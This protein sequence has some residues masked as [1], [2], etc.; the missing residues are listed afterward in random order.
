MSDEHELMIGKG[1]GGGARGGARGGGGGARGGGGGGARHRHRHHGGGRGRGW[2]RG[3]WGYGGPAFVYEVPASQGVD[4]DALLEAAE[5]ADAADEAHTKNVAR[6]VVKHLRAGTAQVGGDLDLLDADIV[7]EGEGGGGGGF[8]DFGLSSIFNLA[9][10][11]AQGGVN[12]YEGEQKKKQAAAGRAK[13]AAEEQSRLQAAI[14]ADGAATQAAARAAFSA[15]Q[16]LASAEVD[17]AAAAQAS[18][19]Q[20]RAG[21]GLSPDSTRKRIEA[22]EKAL[23]AATSKAQAAPKDAYALAAMRA[24]QATL[25]K[26]QN[27]EIVGPEGGGSAPASRA[28]SGGGGGAGWLEGKTGPVPNKVVAGAG[29]LGAL[30]LLFKVLR[31]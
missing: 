14:S 19:A 9:S 8:G 18:G 13:S 3:G 16:K 24:A 27:A 15:A 12:I 31:R 20:A 29:A 26:I 2:G 30:G 23:A 21:A 28:A 25:N 22:A 7:G 1:G 6:E 17:Q 5:I 11:L 10:N 4:I